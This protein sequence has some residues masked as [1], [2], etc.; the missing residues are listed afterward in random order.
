MFPENAIGEEI[1]SV[2]NE[3]C[4]KDFLTKVQLDIELPRS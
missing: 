3:K 2:F 1:E 4:L